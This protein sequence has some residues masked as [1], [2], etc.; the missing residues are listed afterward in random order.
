M[1]VPYRFS[2]SLFFFIDFYRN[3]FYVFYNRQNFW[4][5]LGYNKY[6]VIIDYVIL[7]N[8]G[9]LLFEVCY[10]MSYGVLLSVFFL[11]NLNN[12]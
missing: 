4:V 6:L 11:V 5:Y 7:Y 1:C 3:F 12:I 10:Y 8:V 9:Y 2:F